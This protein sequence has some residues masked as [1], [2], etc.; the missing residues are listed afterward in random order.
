MDK[1]RY[2][3]RGWHKT[4][5]IDFFI[6]VG[7]VFM[8]FLTT[9]FFSIAAVIK[10]IPIP[11]EVYSI[12]VGFGIFFFAYIWDSMAHRSVYKEKI[13][14]MEL[15]VHTFMVYYAGFCLFASF[16]LA[17]WFPGLML[18]FIIGFMFLKTMYS[19][20]D[21]IGYHWPRFKAGRSDMIEMTAHWAQFLGNIVYDV[22]FMYLIYWNKYEVVKALFR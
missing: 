6:S 13:D 11:Q 22:G 14:S 8:A 4:D 2:T 3:F 20:Y 7:S 1:K 12:P 15:K 9:L 10:H 18:S 17:Y 5:Y 19:V 16:I 21:E